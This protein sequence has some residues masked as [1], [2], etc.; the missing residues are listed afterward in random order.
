MFCKPRKIIVGKDEIPQYHHKEEKNCGP[1]RLSVRLEIKTESAW[2]VVK[3]LS[4]A[5][6]TNGLPCELLL[7][8]GKVFHLSKFSEMYIRLGITLRYRATYRLSENKIVEKHY[9]VKV[10]AKRSGCDVP[11][12]VFWSNIARFT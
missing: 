11:R 12:A 7:D 2:D 9:I 8:N 10:N 1:S 6:Q 4:Q 5:L 3:T